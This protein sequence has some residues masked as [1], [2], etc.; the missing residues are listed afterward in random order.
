MF[1]LAGLLLAATPIFPAFAQSAPASP[2]ATLWGSASKG[3]AGEL[4]LYLGQY[5]NGQ[6]SGQAK[7]ALAALAAPGTA[8]AVAPAPAAAAQATQA[9]PANL[10]PGWMIEVRAMHNTGQQSSDQSLLSNTPQANGAWQ[11]DPV[12]LSIQPAPGPDFDVAHLSAAVQGA[13]ALPALAGTAKLAIK[14]GGQWGIG[15]RV[16]WKTIGPCELTLRVEGNLVVDT[17][18]GQDTWGGTG[19]STFSNAVSLT[20][21]LY[22]V[23]WTLV[24]QPAQQH[25]LSP[26]AL[27]TLLVAPPGGALEVPPAGT[28]LHGEKPS[29]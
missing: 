4:Q 10:V 13:G 26:D 12:A 19:D 15:A 11:P 28:F 14:Q 8:A 5:P 18:T 2:D 9:P 27:I 20:P 22:D 6:F 1:P 25:Q 3:A 7:A 16:Q 21:G 24:C 23:A 29:N 17:S